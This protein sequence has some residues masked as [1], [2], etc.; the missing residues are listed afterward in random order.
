MPDVTATIDT[1]V[2]VSLQAADLIGA[3]SVLFDHLLVPAKVRKELIDGGKRNSSALG[4]LKRFAF[5]KHCD[6]Y[7]PEL[8]QVLLDTRQHR[9]EGR[10]EGEAEA[11]IQ[12]AQKRANMV[13]TDDALGREWAHRHSLEC[14]GT[15]W[16]CR[17]LRRTGSLTELRPRYLRMLGSGRRHP[18]EVI[19][20]YRNYILD[21]PHGFVKE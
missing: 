16:I 4:A 6:D 17:E 20:E 19:N 21:K 10:D 13:L 3:V 11:V 15:V 1:S 8:V 14:H 5:L 18:I 12:A 2:L 7:N 9:K